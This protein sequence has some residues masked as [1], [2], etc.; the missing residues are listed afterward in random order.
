ELCLDPVR[1]GDRVE[2]VT[3]VAVD[4]SAEHRLLR[5]T[6]ENDAK[7]RLLAT[8]SH[9]LRTPLSSVIGFAD[10]MSLERSGTLNEV[11]RRQLDHIVSSGRHLLHIVNEILDFSRLA[12]GGVLSVSVDAV[13][14]GPA[15]EE[16]LARIGPIAGARRLSFVAPAEPLVVSADPQ[17]LSQILLN[18]LSNAVRSTDVQGQVTVTCRRVPEGV[19]ISVADDG[20]GIAESDL[21]G[22]FDEYVQAGL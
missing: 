17:R 6:A 9:E 16:A 20:V 10:L 5:V 7:S 15:I 8:V 4:V 14:V 21:A 11:Q 13:P 18:L 1:S 22:I 12:A 2:S 3:G 19:E